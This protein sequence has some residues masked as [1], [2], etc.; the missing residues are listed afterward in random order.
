MTLVALIP[1]LAFKLNKEWMHSDRHID[2]FMAL[3]L[4]NGGNW[5]KRSSI[6]K[7]Q[8]CLESSSDAKQPCYGDRPF[9]LM[10]MYR[11]RQPRST[12]PRTQYSSSRARNSVSPVRIG[13]PGHRP[14]T[15][16][17]DELVLGHASRGEVDCCPPVGVA[18]RVPGRA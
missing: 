9:E 6:Y 5:Y 8:R 12:P 18:G 2:C 1:T 17:L 14:R 15:R 7:V 10:H 3:A 11:E 13:L 4:C 16:H